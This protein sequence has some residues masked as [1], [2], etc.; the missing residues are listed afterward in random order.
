MSTSFTSSPMIRKL[1]AS[2]LL[3][4]LVGLP[5]IA[6]EAESDSTSIARPSFSMTPT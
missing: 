3:A 2:L 4:F 6:E 5:A 1:R